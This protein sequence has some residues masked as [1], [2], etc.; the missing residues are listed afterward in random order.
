MRYHYIISEIY[1]E[2]ASCASRVPN[3]LTMQVLTLPP[4]RQMGERGHCFIYSLA[5]FLAKIVPAA[6]R[7]FTSLKDNTTDVTLPLPPLPPHHATG[8]SDSFVIA[9]FLSL[10]T[11]RAVLLA[12]FCA[13][14]RNPYIRRNIRNFLCP[15]RV[16]SVSEFRKNSRKRA[17]AR[18]WRITKLNETDYE[19]SR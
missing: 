5:P 17:R 6:A 1:Y 7:A 18:T 16:S 4:L 8:Y 12:I 11:P 10:V 19:R 15:D 13:I 14:S 9:S 2:N 3:F